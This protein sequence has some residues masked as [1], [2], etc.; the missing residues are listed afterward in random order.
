M[1]A[2]SC[3]AREGGVLCCKLGQINRLAL[4]QRC[5][6]G[7]QADVCRCMRCYCCRTAS[8]NM[9][10]SGGGRR[11]Y[12]SGQTATSGARAPSQHGPEGQPATDGTLASP[13]VA[14]LVEPPACGQTLPPITDSNLSSPS[15]AKQGLPMQAPSDPPVPLGSD[16]VASQKHDPAS[17]CLVPSA[18]P[19]PADTSHC[20]RPFLDLFAGVHSPLSKAMHALQCN[21]FTPSDLARHPSH[22]I[23]DDRVMHLLQ[24]YSAV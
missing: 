4:L 9:K 11:T 23:L 5:F 18:E 14:Q 2:A 6:C 3:C 12:P 7:I 13:S 20:K 22:D 24:R 8:C 16:Q 10:V 17:H 21:Y 1:Q 19:P 15:L